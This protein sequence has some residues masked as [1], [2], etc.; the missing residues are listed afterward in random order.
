MFFF[1]K[2]CQVF[3]QDREQKL[4]KTREPGSFFD[5]EDYV[6]IIEGWGVSKD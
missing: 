1:T 5:L 2:R 6:I 3:G 4:V